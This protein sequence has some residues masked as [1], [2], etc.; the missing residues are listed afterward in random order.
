MN[1]R[2]TEHPS[3]RTFTERRALYAAT[4]AELVALH[5]G[6]TSRELAILEDYC[7]MQ[8]ARRLTEAARVSKGSAR[9]CEASGR[10]CLTWIPG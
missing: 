1:E 3:N 9:T 7:P 10:R 8:V 5:P 4:V 6:R 2:S